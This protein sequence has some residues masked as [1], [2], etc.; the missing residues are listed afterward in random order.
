MTCIDGIQN[1][2]RFIA[3]VVIAQRLVKLAK[4][5]PVTVAYEVVIVASCCNKPVIRIAVVAVQLP[6]RIVIVQGSVDILGT[7]FRSELAWRDVYDRFVFV[8]PC[9]AESVKFSP[10]A[11]TLVVTSPV[12]EH[13]CITRVCIETG[14]LVLIKW[15]FQSGCAIA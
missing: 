6:I 15:N 10:I 14:L 11:I 9:I 13:G 8:V 2:L 5:N 3:L 4:C 7:A 12:F 1:G